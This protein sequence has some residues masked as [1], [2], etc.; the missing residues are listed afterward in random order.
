ML[1]IWPEGFLATVLNLAPPVQDA[2]K[3]M[4]DMSFHIRKLI[5][6][7]SYIVHQAT[8]GPATFVQSQKN[9][10]DAFMQRAT[11]KSPDASGFKLDCQDVLAMIKVLAEEWKLPE[12]FVQLLIAAAV[13]ALRAITDCS[14]EHMEMFIA[15]LKTLRA[16]RE[17]HAGIH[18]G[19]ELLEKQL[20]RN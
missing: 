4:E 7:V 17:S 3:K 14:Q 9:N 5:A 18:L 6:N 2:G 8:D 15:I 16:R 19:N 20:G 10:P 11:P 13:I 1:E 12:Y